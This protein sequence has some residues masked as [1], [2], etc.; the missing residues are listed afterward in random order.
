MGLHRLVIVLFEFLVPVVD[1]LHDG[2]GDQEALLELLGV[3]ALEICDA[4]ALIGLLEEGLL[5][6]RWQ[7][8]VGIASFHLEATRRHTGLVH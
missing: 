2:L 1:L 8:P 6:H 7:H 3:E 5:R 4:E